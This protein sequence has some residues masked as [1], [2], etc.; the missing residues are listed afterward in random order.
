MNS[1]AMPQ[2]ISEKGLLEKVKDWFSGKSTE[3]PTPIPPPQLEQEQI[4]P[5]PMSGGKRR[6][7]SRVRRHIRSRAHSCK[8]LSKRKSHRR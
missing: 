6:I 3:Q 5:K 8:V 4:R 1:N 2:P 7:R